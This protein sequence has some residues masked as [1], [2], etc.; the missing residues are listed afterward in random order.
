VQ[1]ASALTAPHGGTLIDLF[2]RPE[3]GAALSSSR[4]PAWTLTPAQLCDLELLAVGAFSPLSGF[5]SMEDHQSVCSQM[6]LANGLLW[7]MPVVLEIPEDL[8]SALRPGGV[9][10]LH[11]PDGRLLALQTVEQK[12][13]RDRRAEAHDVFGTSDP[14]HP[15]VA[16]LLHAPPGVCIS[17]PLQMVND[18]RRSDFVHLR[19]SPRQ[20]R[21]RFAAEG[22]E[23]IVA[24]QTRNPMHRAH[25]E[26]TRRA[27]EQSQAHLL[28]HPVVGVTKPGD[29]DYRVRV[30]AYEALL[31]SY[32]AGTVTL[33]LLPLA[34]R[35][36][37]PREALW[38]AI[39]RK[40]YGATHF[41][42]GR[43]HAGPGRDRSGRLFYEPIASQELVSRY[44]SELGMTVLTFP[45][46]V[47]VVELGRFVPEEEVPPGARALVVSGTEQRRRL[48]RGEPLPPWLTPAPVAAA[49]ASAAG[50]PRA[51]SMGDES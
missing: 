51:A 11:G 12:W 47:F 27:A 43:D 46:L 2:A 13:R 14:Y 7:P 41:I 23:R 4:A 50:V 25:L 22:H 8:G 35:M 36:A 44:Q 10:R 40:N 48:S 24:F 17:G 37:G 30:K 3:P 38:H 9:L 45:H 15:G 26:I 29:V 49:L 28:L 31:P 32:P 5:L 16:A 20:L 6:R 33:A 19:H 39:I 42:V 1:P 21:A 34:M 18:V